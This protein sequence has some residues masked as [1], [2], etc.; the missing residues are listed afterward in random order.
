MGALLCQRRPCMLEWEPRGGSARNSSERLML[1]GHPTVFELLSLGVLL[2]AL[3]FNDC[4]VLQQESQAF[5]WGV[6][7][8]ACCRSRTVL[9]GCVS[10]CAARIYH[11]VRYVLVPL[12]SLP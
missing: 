4:F 6:F 2:S 3:L 7:M 12:F 1:C 11:C 8:T 10:S 9:L 5:C